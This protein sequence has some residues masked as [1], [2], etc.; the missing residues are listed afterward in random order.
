[1]NPMN[2][3]R[4]MEDIGRRLNEVMEDYRSRSISLD[5]AYEL[6][7]HLSGEADG[8]KMIARLEGM[9]IPEEE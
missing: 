8:I 1:M 5:K 9:Q 3:K 7:T 2:Y 4:A 6:V